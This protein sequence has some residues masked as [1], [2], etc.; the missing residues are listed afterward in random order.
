[1]NSLAFEKFE[2]LDADCLVQFQGE[3]WRSS[4]WGWLQYAIIKRL[5]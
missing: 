5:C 3:G 1:M 2:S 4:C